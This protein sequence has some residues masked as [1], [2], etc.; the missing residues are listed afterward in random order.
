MKLW[1]VISREIAFENRWWKI[2]HE[3]V[4]LPNGVLIDYYP[5]ETPGGVIIVGV[6]PAEEV[7]LRRQYKHG[8]RETVL[9]LPMGRIDP[10]DKSPEAAARREFREETGYESEEAESLGEFPVFPTS[11]TGTFHPFLFRDAR[12]VGD[13]DPNPQE[14]GELM[15]VPLS[16]V[17]GR[18]RA[19]RTTLNTL[20][21]M[22]VALERLGRLP[23]L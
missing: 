19:E 18:L 3:K 9:E 13:P 1:E 23:S 4:R 16:E 21:A 12:R 17:W 7:I 2:W 10:D 8:I 6:T 22:A 5:N 14:A 15:L 11:S 20:G